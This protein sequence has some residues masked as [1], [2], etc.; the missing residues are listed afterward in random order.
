MVMAIIELTGKAALREY[1]LTTPSRA[2]KGICQHHT[3]IPSVADYKGVKTIEGIRRTHV[4]VNHWRDIGY[5][6]L[7]GP[8]G[9]VFAGREMNDV[10]AHA[11]K[12]TLPT[13]LAQ[14]PGRPNGANEDLIGFCCIGNYD[15]DLPTSEMVK[16][17]GY[18]YA[19]CHARFG[20]GFMPHD[21]WRHLDIHA[22]ACPG[23]NLRDIDWRKLME[24][25]DD[26][27]PDWA[28]PDW[29]EAIDLKI[30]DGTRPNDTVTRAELI[31][32]A[33]RLRRSIIKELKP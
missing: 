23:K 21:H 5:H 13:A 28:E 26:E 24:D 6:V 4:E 33:M 27:V 19:V 15:V 16:M 7:F 11:G 14:W 22:T 30:V 18:A 8:D 3:A 10:G 17:V 31:V 12:I 1:L 25:T 20:S 9:K 32:I 29:Q 2:W